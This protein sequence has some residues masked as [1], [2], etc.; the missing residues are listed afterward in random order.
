MFGLGPVPAV[1]KALL[2]RPAGGSSDVERFEINEAF[3]A[4]P[5]HRSGA[6]PGRGCH[7]CRGWRHRAAIN[8]GNRRCADH[9][10]SA[11]HASRRAPSWHGHAVHWGWSGH[12]V[13]AETIWP[14]MIHGAP[15]GKVLMSRIALWA[16]HL[17]KPARRL[18]SHRRRSWLAAS[19]TIASPTRSIAG[20]DARRWVVSSL[21]T[22][23][24]G[25]ARACA[26]LLQQLNRNTAGA[27]PPKTQGRVPAVAGTSS[28]GAASKGDRPETYRETPFNGRID[29]DGNVKAVGLAERLTWAETA[30]SPQSGQSSL[31]R[32]VQTFHP[33][34]QFGLRLPVFIRASVLRAPAS[35]FVAL[36]ACGIGRHA[37]LCS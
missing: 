9:A 36:T 12:R 19:M 3:A 17:S 29:R 7:Q 34:G 33:D 6:Q 8:Q 35:S 14:V 32:T 21:E 2:A 5:R 11:R 31:T 24:F 1:K 4:V 23:T 28:S 15:G 26:Q 25:K 18:P 30:Y 22:R 10:T 13:G 27:L 20:D 37:A 16:S